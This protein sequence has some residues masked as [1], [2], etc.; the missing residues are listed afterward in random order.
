[1]DLEQF[2]SSVDD[3]FHAIGVLKKEKSDLAEMMPK[4]EKTLTEINKMSS[5]FQKPMQEAS[6]NAVETYQQILSNSTISIK[7]ETDVLIDESRRLKKAS[8]GIKEAADRIRVFSVFSVGLSAIGICLLAGVV[9]LIY[10]I[11]EGYPIGYDK[12]FSEGTKAREYQI[13]HE[14]LERI[15]LKQSEVKRNSVILQLKP[16][17]QLFGKQLESGYFI[18]VYK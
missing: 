8:S 11:R 4:V 2:R 14:F 3:L 1:M 13:E 10:G 7:N 15:G 12:G 6:K 9:G 5:F 18:R 16:G 17:Y